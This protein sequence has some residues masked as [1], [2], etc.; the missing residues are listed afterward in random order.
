MR[1]R[2]IAYLRH[3]VLGDVGDPLVER[4]FRMNVTLCIHRLCTP[5]EAAAAGRLWAGK[6][7]RDLAGQPIEIIEERG[8]ESGPSC[9]PCNNPRRLAIIPSRPDL[10]VPQ[11]CGA[12]PSCEARSI[13]EKNA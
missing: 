6:E 5:T 10:W 1:K 7:M 13:L 12:C 4:V 8:C 11:D 3:R 2:S 9:Q